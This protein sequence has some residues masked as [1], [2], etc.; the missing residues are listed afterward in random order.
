[1]QLDGNWEWQLYLRTDSRKKV[2]YSLNAFFTRVDDDVSRRFSVTP[3]ITWRVGTRFNASGRLSYGYNI[4]DR[5]YIQ[6]IDYREES[7]FI[8]GRLD[9]E[10]WSLTLRADYAFTPDL[11][12]QYYA[13]PFISAG[14]YD[15]LKSV[16]DADAR[17]YEQRY[18][19]FEDNDISRNPAANSLAL[20]ENGDGTT[21][22]TIQNPDFNFR[23]IRSNMV[24]RWEYKPGSTFYF[25]WTHGRSAYTNETVR[26]LGK[27][28]HR[29]FKLDA[30]NIF[31]MKF[32]YW[33]SL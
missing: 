12:L 23:E 29:L 1:L 8:L 21:D 3:A 15:H 25:V 18:H 20:D 7:R 30:Q 14:K 9:Q 6:T 11:I 22:Y 27:N 2:H 24:L 10:T 17:K 33:F 32:N 19:I 13:S 26:S 16:M 5:Q 4:D 28:A 31:M